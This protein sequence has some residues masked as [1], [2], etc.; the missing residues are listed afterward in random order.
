MKDHLRK[1]GA[2]AGGALLTTVL[3]SGCGGSS[4]SS[5]PT[6]TSEPT[7][8]QDARTFTVDTAELP[9]AALPN[10]P[11]SDRWY[12]VRPNGAGYRVE[13]PQNWNGM[14]VM[15]AH[16]YRGTGSKLTVDSPLIR[17]WLLDNGYAW[18]ASSYSANYY[19]VRAGLEDTNE[20]ALAFNSIAEANGRPLATPTKIYITGISMGG[21]ITAAAVEDENMAAENHKVA[22][23]GAAP[24]CGVVAG[25]YEFDY[26][27]NFTFAAQ[28]LANQADSSSP[29]LD[30][31]PATN[32]D[33]N[34]IN[35]VMWTTPPTQTSQGTPSAAG[36]KL[37]GLVENLTGGTRPG[38]M[39]GY[40]SFYWEVVM[41]NGGTDGT[42][43]G[44]LN[45]PLPGNQGYVYQLDND[46]ALS[47]DE[48]TLNDNILRV[49]ADPSANPP[50]SDGLRWIPKV[51]GQFHVPVVTIH[52]LGDLYVPFSNEQL[53]RQRAE[54]NG[55]GYWLVQRAIR[56]TYHCDFTVQEEVNAF[57][58][59]VRWDQTGL[60]PSG[61]D[62]TNAS[63]IS[64]ANYG[65]TY[66]TA[67]VS[68]VDSPTVFAGHGM[69]NS[70]P[71]P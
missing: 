40:N 68:G 42:I 56:G 32:F 24:M 63:T 49:A 69:F 23:N 2:A 50:R 62:V 1:L 44:I 67:P 5:T 57:S 9:F 41:S 66:T 19:D 10:H 11:N 71:A 43:N 36:M 26:L 20:L 16:G 18:A 33:I 58:A 6:A 3:L 34:K 65:C 38:F 13:V 25:T 70:C 28:Y 37:A 22:Y 55:S 35:S 4:S 59:M 7:R 14:L 39:G 53:Y 12:G 29:P 31:F 54:A 52:D 15:Y 64:N 51:N 47:T 48:Q 61:D 17:Q 45:K 30:S 60:K 27:T 46:P 21:H 8:P